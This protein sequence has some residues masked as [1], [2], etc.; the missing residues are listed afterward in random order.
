MIIEPIL[1]MAGK[2]FR[3]YFYLQRDTLSLLFPGIFVAF[4]CYQYDVSVTGHHGCSLYSH[5]SICYAQALDFAPRPILTS[6]G[7]EWIQDL[8]SSDYRL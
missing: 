4:A 5:Q 3:Q 6:S 8:H 7:Q 1:N 2:C